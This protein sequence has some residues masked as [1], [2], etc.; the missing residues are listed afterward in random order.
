MVLGED[1]SIPPQE[2]R[3][4]L[5]RNGLR[6]GKTQAGEGGKFSFL[7]LTE[8]DYEVKIEAPGHQTYE[9]RISLRYPGHEEERFSVHLRPL[10]SVDHS[11]RARERGGSRVPTFRI[12]SSQVVVDLVALEKNGRFIK[13]LGA[14]DLEIFED[15]KK[16]KINFFLAP[17]QAEQEAL[18]SALSSPPGVPAD[19]GTG[20]T[21]RAGRL[22]RT[23]IVVDGRV[24][25]SNHFTRSLSAIRRLIDE[26]LARHYRVMLTQMDGGLRVLTPFTRDRTTLLSGLARLKPQRV[27]SPLDPSRNSAEPQQQVSSV[28]EGLRNLCYM[29]SGQPGRKHVVYF[30]VGDRLKDAG[31]F[32]MLRDVISVANNFGISFYTIDARLLVAVP[33][34]GSPSRRG[35]VATGLAQDKREKKAEVHALLESPE[36]GTGE[37]HLAAFTSVEIGRLEEAPNSLVALAAG[38]NGAAFFNTNDLTSVVRASTAKQESYYLVGYTPSSKRKEGHF[39]RISVKTRR[40]GLHI[41]ARKGYIDLPDGTLRR[42]R[43]TAAFDRPE[44][45]Q[46]LS[47]LLRIEASKKGIQCVLGVP[48]GQVAFRRRDQQFQAELAFLGQI[49]DGHG[50]AVSQELPIRRGF[51]LNLNREQF[52]GLGNQPLLARSQV[53]LQAG[54][55]RL[56][57]LV[58]DHLSGALGTVDQQFSVP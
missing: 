51:K 48:A 53:T 23:A 52:Q 36:A 44:L 54:Q 4:S 15:G 18:E 27:Y 2:I 16:Q 46:E 9:R 37:I 13:D 32:P 31:V 6:V 28:R 35:G 10:P 43:M 38:T 11:S 5:L 26:H 25:D 50:Q 8:G 47:P 21:T 49:Y 41:Q 24:M 20:A 30:S 55:Y 34:V 56:V 57:L 45:F 29:L 33:G 19:A 42:A 7:Q 3:I 40:A 12:S 1:L 17:G 58:E 22:S 14:G 39:H